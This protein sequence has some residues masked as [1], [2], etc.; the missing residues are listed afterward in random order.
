MCIRDSYIPRFSRAFS[1][2]ITSEIQ[3]L[4]VSYKSLRS[5]HNSAEI[6]FFSWHDLVALRV[7]P[8]D[9]PHST[10]NQITSS[11]GTSSAIEKLKVDFEDILGDKLD[12]SVGSGC[13]PMT[14]HLT[15]QVIAPLHVNV[16]RQIPCL[17]YTS[18]SPR[19]GLLSRMPSSA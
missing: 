5:D 3:A 15:D 1:L 10:I 8:P 11:A 7:L 4:V 6:F 17:L 14:I 18:P 16:A 9:F 13:P 12:T 2:F 19:D